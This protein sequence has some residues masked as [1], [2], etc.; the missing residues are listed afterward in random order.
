MSR[1]GRLPAAVAHASAVA[2]GGFAYVVGGS[3]ADG[4]TVGTITQI[5]LEH[6]SIKALQSRSVPVSDSAALSLGDHA[7]F[8]GGLRSGSAVNDVRE[9]RAH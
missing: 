3:D 7:M 6:Q 4:K 9:L 8:F 5:D 1:I 2:L